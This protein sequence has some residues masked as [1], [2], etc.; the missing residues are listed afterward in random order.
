VIRTCDE[1]LEMKRAY[2][3]ALE[4]N[5]QDLLEAIEVAR[6]TLASLESDY[7]L[8]FGSAPSASRRP[9]AGRSS[10]VYSRSRKAETVEE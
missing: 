5:R 8:L 9:R 3:A 2:E 4:Q 1:I 7:N 10:G 6:D